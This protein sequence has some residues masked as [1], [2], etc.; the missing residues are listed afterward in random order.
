MSFSLFRLAGSVGGATG[1]IL[2]V[3]GTSDVDKKAGA[4]ARAAM[5]EGKKWNH[6]ALMFEFALKKGRVALTGASGKTDFFENRLNDHSSLP[7][8][9]LAYCAHLLLEKANFCPNIPNPYVLRATRML[10]LWAN[11]A[12]HTATIHQ[13]VIRHTIQECIETTY[14]GLK[15]F[16]MISNDLFQN[17][18]SIQAS[19]ITRD[20]VTVNKP[21]Y[22][23]GSNRPK[24]NGNYNN[25]KRASPAATRLGECYRFNDGTGCDGSCGYYHRCKYCHG[26]HPKRYCPKEQ[27]SP[28]FKKMKQFSNYPPTYNQRFQA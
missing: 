14:E 15:N 4:K 21:R 23:A 24:N 13:T 18:Q 7:C 2:Q 27:Q 11:F 8:D 22:N 6:D 17:M 16:G 10:Q 5:L 19:K 9:A 25:F 28:P 1:F 3:E 26:N 20:L 12:G